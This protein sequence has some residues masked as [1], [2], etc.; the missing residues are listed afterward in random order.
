MEVGWRA[1]RLQHKLSLHGIISAS[2][3][4]NGQY[5]LELDKFRLTEIPYQ[6]LSS[7]VSYIK[8]MKVVF[9]KL[10]KWSLLCEEQPVFKPNYAIKRLCFA[11]VLPQN[12]LIGFVLGKE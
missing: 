2:Q 9:M 4:I 5:S 10:E 11:F 6:L 8:E 12:T 7:I 1:P 3:R